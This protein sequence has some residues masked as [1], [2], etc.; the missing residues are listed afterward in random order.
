M[1][2]NNLNTNNNDLNASMSAKKMRK[3][4]RKKREKSQW[5]KK[6]FA[7]QR[8]VGLIQALDKFF[9]KLPHLPEKIN[10]FFVKVLPIFVLLFGIV[11]AIASFL[12]FAFLVLSL[13]AWDLQLILSSLSSFLLVFVNTL[14]LLKAFKLLK[15][16]DA[17]GWIYIFWTQVMNIAYSVFDMFQGELNV[18]SGVASLVIFTYLLFEIGPFYTYREE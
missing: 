18:Y 7:G 15:R 17:I 12:S 5:F 1:M 4:R 6:L 11:G 8:V 14:L 13:V 16:K 9:T 10:L 2:E 3:L